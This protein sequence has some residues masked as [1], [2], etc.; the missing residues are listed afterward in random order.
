[1]SCVNPISYIENSTIMKHATTIL[2]I[3]LSLLLSSS[4]KAQ[5]PGTFTFVFLTDIHVQPEKQADQGFLKAI[6]AV[7]ALN[8][9]FVITGG[10]LIMDALGQTRERADSLYRL[11]LDL[12]LD[13][14]MPVYHTPGNHEHFAYYMKDEITPDD[15]D[16]GDGMYKRYL[17]RT[18]YSFN[19]K[20]WH[21]IV[22]NSVM[23]T[24]DRGY[25]G[26][27]SQDQLVWLENDLS[28]VSDD[29]P[30]ALSVH[31]PLL[32]VQTQLRS[33][34]LTAHR[35]GSVINNSQEVLQLFEGKNLRLVLQGHLHALEEINLNN[36]VRFI[37][38]GAVSANWW[39]GDLRGLQEGFL[40]VQVTGQDFDWEYVDFGWEAVQED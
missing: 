2:L 38:A 9:D 7:N 30:I 13:F 6:G 26:G 23:E 11:Y 24:E 31:I 29:M 15:P 32:S 8:P 4:G 16:Y 12:A 5:E 14:N 35:E 37:T 27:V 39:N 19:H 10:D 40:K 1:M 22:L 34:N 33:G 18:H 36:Q 21:F 17:G 3:F 28:A 20:G 25:R